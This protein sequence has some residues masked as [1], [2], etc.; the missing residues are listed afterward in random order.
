MIADVL[1]DEQ[2][3]CESKLFNEMME[4]CCPNFN[5]DDKSTWV[6]RSMP[7]LFGKA[8]QGSTNNMAHSDWMWFLRLCPQMKDIFRNVHGTEDLCVS[9]D[10]FSLDWNV[11]N[12]SKSW[13]HED[14][15]LNISPHV[16]SVQG[17]YNAVAVTETS[18]GFCC[19]PGSHL[20]AGR[21]HANRLVKPKKNYVLLEE[22]SPEHDNSVKLLVPSNSVV[23]WNSFLLHANECGTAN[24]DEGWNRR[25]AFICMMPK[26]IRP[27]D[28]LVAKIQAYRNGYQG[29][30]W[31]N[32]WT[33]K[34]NP[35]PR[36]K[37]LLPLRDCTIK[38]DEGGLIPPD[39][40]E[41]F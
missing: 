8:I 23:L 26:V 38:F 30:H 31:A 27:A 25:S 4:E 7:D 10:G 12:R 15:A 17:T 1:S 37:Y 29:T 34:M 20:T 40:F 22:D 39:R 5:K 35:Y 13:L 14:Q 28:V 18:R 33:R 16:F 6:N 2:I 9:F 21:R 24:N 19:V 3:A 41:L 11:E 32:H 36:N